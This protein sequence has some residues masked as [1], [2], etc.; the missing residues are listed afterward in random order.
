MKKSTY[1]RWVWV[2][3]FLGVEVVFEVA[4]FCFYSETFDTMASAGCSDLLLY[5]P[6]YNHCNGM[7][8]PVYESSCG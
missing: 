5:T 3:L 4:W 6:G 2:S 1:Q 8:V 7:V